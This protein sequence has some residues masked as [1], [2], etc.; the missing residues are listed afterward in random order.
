MFLKN[1]F[2]PHLFRDLFLSF[3]FDYLHLFMS[4][5]T[6]GF[7]LRSVFGNTEHSEEQDSV[8]AGELQEQALQA[9]TAFEG[10][11]WSTLSSAGMHSQGACMN[12]CSHTSVTRL[13]VWSV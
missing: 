5:I 3:L 1:A 11:L 12:Q 9:Q 8:C 10:S 2:S 13:L 4:L 7:A 6:G